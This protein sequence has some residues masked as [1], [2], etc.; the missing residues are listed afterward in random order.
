M[1]GAV[2]L[3]GEELEQRIR[4]YIRFVELETGAPPD[5]IYL[6]ESEWKAFCTAMARHL[7]AVK[8][9][10]AYQ[11]LAKEEMLQYNGIPVRPFRVER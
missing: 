11:E 4:T 9:P 2:A 8:Q 10:I 1:T 5:V 7:V 3:T 6:E